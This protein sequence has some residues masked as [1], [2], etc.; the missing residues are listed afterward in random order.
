MDDSDLQQLREQVAELRSRVASL[1]KIIWAEEA[2][3]PERE[4][5]RHTTLPAVQQTSQ[6]PAPQAV[7]APVQ[8]PLPPVA[9]ATGFASAAPAPA[10]HSA[11]SL[12][13]R[14][15]SQWFNRI[16][17]LA[18][19][20][21]MSWFLK[22]AIDNH[23][24]GPLGRVVIGMVAGAG[25]IGWSERFHRKGYVIFSYSLK[26]I[27]SGILYLSLWAAFSVF[28]LI[29]SSV[30]F[31]A[32][33]AV[34]AFNGY[35]SWL[36]NSEILAL[37]SIVGGFSTPL[38]LS[39]G[40]NHEVS[41]FTYLLILNVAVLLL[42]ALR[43]WSRLLFAAFTGTVLFFAAWWARFY[44]DDQLGRTALFL[45]CFILLFAFAPRL[46]RTR[47]EDLENIP[48]WDRLATVL[49]P[50]A[51]AALG[52]LA[53]YE[54]LDR[55]ATQWA[56]P[57][58]AV[59]FAAFY[60]LI[61]KLPARGPLK[62][63]STLSSALLLTTAIVFL[64]I[65]IPLKTQGRWLTIGWLVQGAAMLWLAKR[66]N[67]HLLGTLALICLVLGL[68]ALFINNPPASLTPLWNE[69]FAT[70]CVAIAVS[71]FVALL[72]RNAGAGLNQE[73][74]IPWPAVAVAAALMISV[75]ILV[76]ISWEIH[77]YWWYVRWRGDWNF[78]HDYRM[79]AQ[80]TY[81]AFFMLYGAILLTIGFW[82][83]SSFV[84]WQALVL[85]AAA[86]AKVFLG[87]IG[88]LSQGYR[89]LSFLGL[90]VLLLAV[91]FAYQRDWLHLRAPESENA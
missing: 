81:S 73:N 29:P 84:R 13:S 16:G 51:N 70:C 22:L 82:R 20:I 44:T 59:A 14:I 75:L 74:T 86:I 1:E 69:R 42:A 5:Q 80:F 87:D 79:Y 40:E 10:Q 90:G 28:H 6:T 57:W 41:L 89:I 36:R 35:M 68:G 9:T 12:E 77:S 71:V 21:A 58:L 78:M 55:P 67:L 76:A 4:P 50:I 66:V 43:P 45:A 52:F 49:M 19:L 32:M 63:N 3:A 39:T 33:I 83:R 31:A 48:L 47:R 88:S 61:L 46:L 27:G 30:A 24:I 34:T 8:P 11:R 85:L 54:L 53:F 26:A 38:L 2:S 64:T 7:V 62:A 18:V 25:L 15:G 56:S 23:W 91:S 17:I 72:A 37:Y 60:L 65:A